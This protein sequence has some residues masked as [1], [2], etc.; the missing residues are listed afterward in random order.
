MKARVETK[1]KHPN[2]GHVIFYNLS[3]RQLE[4]IEDIAILSKAFNLL[5]KNYKKMIDDIEE[6]EQNKLNIEEELAETIEQ[7]RRLVIRLKEVNK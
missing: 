7:N 6:L 3:P 2:Y 1:I 5:N 4:I